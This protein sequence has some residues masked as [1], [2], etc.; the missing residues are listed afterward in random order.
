MDDL[1]LTIDVGTGSVRAALVDRRGKVL[2]IAARE[3]EQIVP[4]FG[5]SEQRPEDWWSGVA[6]ATRAVLDRIAPC[7]SRR[8]ALARASAA[9]TSARAAATAPWLRLN[10]GNG[11]DSPATR[12]VASS[13]LN[14][15]TPTETSTSG[16]AFRRSSIS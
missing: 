6:A 1:F 16:I 13:P 4:Q 15:R 14:W 12:A 7:A 2:E 10:S 9:E 5:W 11:T 3:H 8:A